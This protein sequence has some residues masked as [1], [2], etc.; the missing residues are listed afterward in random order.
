MS[1]YDFSQYPF[2][3]ALMHGHSGGRRHDGTDVYAG[4]GGNWQENDAL[5]QAYHAYRQQHG[6]RPWP[7]YAYHQQQPPGVP[8]LPDPVGEH[9][10]RNPGWNIF[11]ALQNMGWVNPSIPGVV[12]PADPGTDTTTSTDTST[13][14]D[15]GGGAQAG[16]MRSVYRY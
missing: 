16:A 2:L 7:N 14:S 15:T 9:R 6:R 3:N 10:N 1:S 11:R 5:R 12:P 4:G 8:G 13:G